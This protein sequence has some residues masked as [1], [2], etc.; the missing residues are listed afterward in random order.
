[1]CVNLKTRP[2][3]TMARRGAQHF[4]GGDGVVRS[5]RVTFRY[6][7][8][9]RPNSAAQ[10]RKRLPSPWDASSGW[11]CW[12]HQDVVLRLTLDAAPSTCFRPTMLLL[13]C[14]SRARRQRRGTL[15][16]RV[17]AGPS[18]GNPFSTRYSEGKAK[19][20]HAGVAK[21]DRREGVGRCVGHHA[22][23]RSSVTAGCRPCRKATARC[24]WAAAEKI[25]RLSLASTCSHEPR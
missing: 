20:L 12:S 9:R 15:R 22:A 21:A 18:H 10:D 6:V 8:R 2:E 19:T 23:S 3:M 4:I 17:S 25:A 16:P 11:L 5:A 14:R 7:V 24:A 13:V 1:M